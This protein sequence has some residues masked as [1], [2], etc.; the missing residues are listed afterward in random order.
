MRADP[1]DVTLGS[2]PS[3]TRSHHIISQSTE[4]SKEVRNKQ[5]LVPLPPQVMTGGKRQPHVQTLHCGQGFISLSL[6]PR[7]DTG[8]QYVARPWGMDPGGFNPAS[9]T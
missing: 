4:D 7:P 1:S 5:K 2:F 9:T 6:T 8:Q 3:T